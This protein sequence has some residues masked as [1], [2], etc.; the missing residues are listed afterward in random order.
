MNV[1]GALLSMIKS[2]KQLI[3]LISLGLVAVITTTNLFATGYYAGVLAGYGNTNWTR[4]STSNDFLT[5]SLP[6]GSRD[7]GLSWGIFIGDDYSQHFGVEL[8]FQQFADS[9]IHFARF[10]NYST[11]G[12]DGIAPAF[13]MT[14]R[15]NSI[16]L[17]SRMRV[18][19]NKSDTLQAYSVL[20]ASATHRSDILRKIAKLSGVFGAGMQYKMTQHFTSSAEFDFITGDAKVDL[21]P[22]AD[23][24][25]FLTTVFYKLSYYF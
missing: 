20:G 2:A 12:T 6:D 15:T 17:L 24:L 19:I 18:S 1:N 14:S 21:K 5:T 23:Y 7:D 22:A 8:R 13:T 25:P 16:Q 10:N 3:T 9:S 4:I 11:P